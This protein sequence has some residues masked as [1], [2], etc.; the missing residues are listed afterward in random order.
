MLAEAGFQGQPEML[1]FR[2]FFRV[3]FVLVRQT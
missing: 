3:V 1:W 2:I